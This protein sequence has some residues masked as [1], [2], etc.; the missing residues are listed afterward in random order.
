MHLFF[1]SSSSSSALF[2]NVDRFEVGEFPDVTQ[3]LSFA[4]VGWAGWR[5]KALR[6]YSCIFSCV[7]WMILVLLCY[8]RGKLQYINL[9]ALWP[10]SSSLISL[11]WCHIPFFFFFFKS[12]LLREASCFDLYK[13]SFF[14]KK[15]EKKYFVH[16]VKPESVY[17]GKNVVSEI[18]ASSKQK[19][20]LKKPFTINNMKCSAVRKDFWCLTNKV[21]QIEAFLTDYCFLWSLFFAV[22]D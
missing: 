16:N 12:S 6:V 14:K 18:I 8:T 17:F 15:M 4:R 10:H 9:S 1:S 2:W 21:N 13:R 5:Q 22:E 7:S 20:L 3:T 11:S 19:Q